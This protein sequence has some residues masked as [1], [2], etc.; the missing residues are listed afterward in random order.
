MQ[1]T[2][3]ARAQ[4]GAAQP[5]ATLSIG[6]LTKNEAARIT[7]CLQS[8]GFA[9]QVVVV[10]SGSSDGTP[11]F[12]LKAGAQVHHYPDWQGFA[13]QRQRLLRHMHGDYVFFLDADELIS[14]ELQRGLRAWVRDGV[15]QVGRV[16]WLTIA[17]GQK[18]PWIY[19]SG[20]ERFFPRAALQGFAG[21]VH[22]EAQLHL[23]LPV[24]V[25]PGRL[26]HCACGSVRVSLHKLTQYAL[27][28]A[29]KRKAVGGTGG[30]LRGISSGLWIF[31]RLYL[32]RLG[33]LGGA[34]GFVYCYVKAQEF[35]FR[36]VALRFDR[37]DL[38]NTVGRGP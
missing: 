32:F 11:D 4:C 25:L 28:G 26:L 35:F 12:A 17:Y 7:A 6:V 8:A 22:E 2:T 3:L 5:Q 13:E 18:L 31:L 21:V 36:Q 19:S 27:L 23:A 10:D 29:A 20:P 37:D 16:R 9:D 33:F 14:P 24:R 34:A 30:V 38:P 1:S 15:Q